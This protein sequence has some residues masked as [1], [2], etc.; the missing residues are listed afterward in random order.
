MMVFCFAFCWEHVGK[1]QGSHD[2]P[3]AIC[4]C[5]EMALGKFRKVDEIQPKYL[6][7]YLCKYIH[8]YSPRTQ[9]TSFFAGVDLPFHG[10]NL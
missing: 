7:I 3:K 4:F 5:D 9:L 2:F 6:Y 8:V 1:T 10:S